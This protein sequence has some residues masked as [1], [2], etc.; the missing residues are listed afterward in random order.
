[1]I[2]IEGQGCKTC[3]Y[4]TYDIPKNKNYKA[5]CKLLKEEAQYLWCDKHKKKMKMRILKKLFYKKFLEVED[6]N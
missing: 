3:K 6:E 1:M 5:Y 2:K 4:C